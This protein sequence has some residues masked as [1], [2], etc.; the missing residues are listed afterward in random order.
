[1]C[2]CVGLGDNK[3]STTK[4]YNRIYYIIAGDSS[5]EVVYLLVCN[6]LLNLLWKVKLS[7]TNDS[8]NYRIYLP[9]TNVRNF[10]S[11]E[12]KHNS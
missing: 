11:V 9:S 6:S 1:M 8:T 12:Q 4:H 3:D 2:F 10:Q 5:L 7:D